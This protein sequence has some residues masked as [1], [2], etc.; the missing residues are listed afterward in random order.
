MKEK[1]LSER[2]ETEIIRYEY[3]IILDDGKIKSISRYYNMANYSCKER[4]NL[5]YEETRKAFYTLAKSKANEFKNLYHTL[6]MNDTKFFA[7]A[8][9]VLQEI[10][11]EYDFCFFD[12]LPF[13]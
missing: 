2:F 9:N 10:Q 12:V 3:I 8:E 5:T 7:I 1:R 11:K 6:M 13:H 4:E